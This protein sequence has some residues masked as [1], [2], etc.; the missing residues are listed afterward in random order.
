MNGC[1]GGRQAEVE[2]GL[3]KT[4]WQW[5]KAEKAFPRRRLNLRKRLRMLGNSGSEHARDHGCRPFFFF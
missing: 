5:I 3:A 1:G 2:G 4:F